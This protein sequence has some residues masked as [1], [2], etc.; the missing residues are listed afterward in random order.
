MNKLAKKGAEGITL[1]CIEIPLLISQ[2]HF[3][4]PLLSTFELH[5]EAIA[6]YSITN[7]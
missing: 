6:Q 5:A 3:D 4:Q 7:K 1:R 2:N